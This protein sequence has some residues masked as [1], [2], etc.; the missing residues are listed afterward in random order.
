LLKPESFDIRK[1]IKALLIIILG[2]L[3]INIKI[4]DVDIETAESSEYKDILRIDRVANGIL[5]II[6]SKP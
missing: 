6:Y 1:K 4:L 2:C 3:E 5:A